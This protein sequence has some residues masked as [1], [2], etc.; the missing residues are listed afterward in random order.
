MHSYRLENRQR[1]SMYA[2]LYTDLDDMVGKYM[3]MDFGT[4]DLGGDGRCNRAFEET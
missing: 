4:M 1:R 2:S 3:N